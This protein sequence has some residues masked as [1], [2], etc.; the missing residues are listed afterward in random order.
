MANK[1]VRKLITAERRVIMITRNVK[2]RPLEA[3]RDAKARRES[4][5]KH[6]IVRRKSYTANRDAIVRIDNAIAENGE[7]E[8]MRIGIVGN[9]A[10]VV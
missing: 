4:F 1:N 2:K 3:E 7:N 10:A 6:V 5:V 9:I 8:T